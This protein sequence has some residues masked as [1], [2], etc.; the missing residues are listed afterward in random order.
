MA[1][2]SETERIEILMIIGYGDR[3]RSC[4]AYVN[5]GF[6]SICGI[7]HTWIAS[8][9]TASTCISRQSV[10]SFKIPTEAPPGARRGEAASGSKILM[11]VFPE[12]RC[13]P[14]TGAGGEPLPMQSSISPAM[15]E[16][17]LPQPLV[18]RS[19]S[20][21]LL[22]WPNSTPSPTKTTTPTRQ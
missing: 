15:T 22:K 3:R 10:R 19:P 9:F 12:P 17:D 20:V 2:L 7:L 18:V 11:V 6:V 8:N 4:E 1:R 14:M 13:G 16:S 21:S 5:N